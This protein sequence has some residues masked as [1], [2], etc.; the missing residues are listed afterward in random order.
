MHLEREH[1][2]NITELNEQ[3][4]KIEN[5]TKCLIKLHDIQSKVVWIRVKNKEQGPRDRASALINEL[6]DNKCVVVRLPA[7]P[8]PAA[9]NIAECNELTAIVG[10]GER[11]EP[12]RRAITRSITDTQISKVSTPFSSFPTPLSLNNSIKEEDNDFDEDGGHET[13]PQFKSKSSLSASKSSH[14]IGTSSKVKP[15]PPRRIYTMDFL[16]KRADA[17][18]SKRLPS[19]WKE[20]NQKYPFICFC[21]KVIA[22]F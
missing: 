2:K 9:T 3:I 11:I 13:M 19:N 22:F 21:G 12:K 6:T 16:L 8:E 20:L 17:P 18:A 15:P 1:I 14:Q 10:G 5:E 7:I 4:Q